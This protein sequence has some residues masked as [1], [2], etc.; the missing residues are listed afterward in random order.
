MNAYHDGLYANLM[1]L[2]AE[3]TQNKDNCFFYIDQKRMGH[4]FRIFMYRLARYTD[5]QKPG[6]LSCRGLMYAMDES[7]MPTHCASYPMDKFFNKD[8]NPST[9]DLDYRE[10]RAVYPKHDGSLISTYMIGDEVYV[11]SKGSLGSIQ[12]VAAENYI[13]EHPALKKELA[14]LGEMGFT[15]NMEYCAPDNRIVLPYAHPV[16]HIIDVRINDSGYTF[17]PHEWLNDLV[18]RRTYPEVLNRMIPALGQK[19]IG[20]NEQQ[21][22]DG[23][24]KME[25]IEGYVVLTRA[26]K[27]VKIKTEWYQIRHKLKD[28]VT[29]PKALLEAIITEQVDDIRVMFIGDEITQ[30]IISDMEDKVMPK[31]NA[32]LADVAAFHAENKNLT[33]KDYAIKATGLNDGRLSLYMNLFL[34]KENDYN[35]WV[36]KN[37]EQFIGKVATDETLEEAA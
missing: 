11:K 25:S 35:E 15:V 28:S 16:L 7:M 22:I 13:T 26:S 29:N 27:R 21:L 33:R 17:Y 18:M 12:A 31:Y 5:F 36:L 10:L 19:V 8:E 32:L 1:A 23:I 30:K 4:L 9:M 37:Y 20:R 24:P 34:N 6:A 14:D 2:C 3:S